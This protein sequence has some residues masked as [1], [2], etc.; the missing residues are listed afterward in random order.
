MSVSTFQIAVSRC[1]NAPS[2]MALL[3]NGRGGLDIVFADTVT[4]Q[5]KVRSK[6]KLYIA[7]IPAYTEGEKVKDIIRTVMA[8]LA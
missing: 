5:H 6:N 4:A 8:A 1:S 2:P 7:T 3:S